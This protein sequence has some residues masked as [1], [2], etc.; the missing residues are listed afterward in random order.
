MDAIT[1]APSLTQLPAPLFR[2]LVEEAPLAVSITDADGRILYVNPSFSRITGYPAEAL[3]GTSHSLLSYKVTPREVYEAMWSAISAGQRWQ[4]R[5]INRRRDGERYVAE[6]SITPIKDEAGQVRYFLGLQQ[7]VTEL[8]ALNES[9]QNQKRLIETIIDLAPVAVVLLDAQE[10]VVLDNQEYRK[11]MGAFGKEEPAHA[12]LTALRADVGEAGW[13]RIQQRG[14][15]SPHT[16]RFDRGGQS[17]PCWY[18]VSGNGFEQRDVGVDSYFSDESQRYLLLVIADNTDF[19]RR[20]Q[21]EWLQALRAMLSEG[22]LIARLRETLAGAAFQLSGPL[23]VIAAAE[24][25]LIR[26][27]PPCDPAL[28]ALGEARRQ[29]ENALELLRSATPALPPEA[30]QPLNCNELLHDV[31][32]VQTR[33]LLGEGVVVDW[34]PA[35]RLPVVRGQALALRG[36]LNQLVLNALDSMHESRARHRELRLASHDQ[37]EWVELEVC[38]SG[39][40]IPEALRLKVFEPFFTTR[41]GGARAGMGL[42]LAQEVIRQHQGEL[43]IDPLYQ[44]GCRIV[45]RLPVE[46]GASHV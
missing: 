4:G 12:L 30:W 28:A 23:N 21:A 24:R 22:E 6:L 27:L 10:A 46:A 31:L 11:L 18:T 17:G 26:R 29:G 20:Q 13:A 5:L 42:T 43:I 35:L 19:K 15:F 14:E 39:A 16:L 33:R 37:G 7:D 8:H 36:A 3:V 34:Q 9:L 32:Q 25:Q 1:P 41:P 40:G 45:V 44:P 2:E 38:D